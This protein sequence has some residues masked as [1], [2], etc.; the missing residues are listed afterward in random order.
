MLAVGPEDASGA[1]DASDEDDG[2]DTKAALSLR[3]QRSTQAPA[4]SRT[5]KRRKQT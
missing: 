2:R 3:A 5:A 1:S 4:C